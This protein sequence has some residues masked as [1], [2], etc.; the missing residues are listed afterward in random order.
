MG[1]YSDLMGPVMVASH[2][3]EVNATIVE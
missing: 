3:A 2:D 1:K